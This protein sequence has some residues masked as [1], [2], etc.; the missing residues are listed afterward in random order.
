MNKISHHEPD[1]KI[2]LAER[3]ITAAVSA[4]AASFTL[5][6]Y[7]LFN[8]VFASKAPSGPPAGLFDPIIFRMLLS[9]VVFAAMAGFFLGS[10]RMSEAFGRLWGTS[11]DDVVDEPWFRKLKAMT[12]LILLVWT[13]ILLG[14][15][16]G[17]YSIR[18][19]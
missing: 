14:H 2:T 9:L 7:Y 13:V 10:S 1:G 16:T 17:F 19:L 18:G 5:L 11:S 4:I 8:L 6:A 12:A 15:F 3:I